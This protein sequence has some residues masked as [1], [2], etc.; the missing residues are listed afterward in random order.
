MTFQRIRENFKKFTDSWFLCVGIFFIITGGGVIYTGHKYYWWFTPAYSQRQIAQ[1]FLD[2]VIAGRFS[3]AYN[4][5]SKNFQ[6]LVSYSVF[7]TSVSKLENQQ[8]KIGYYSYSVAGAKTTI[9]GTMY[10]VKTKKI[11]E[12]TIVIAKNETNYQVATLVI[13]NSS[14]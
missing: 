5:T 10:N 8:F 4:E 2:D 3:G 6:A 7:K 13:T 1:A 11:D 14:S 12:L 9:R